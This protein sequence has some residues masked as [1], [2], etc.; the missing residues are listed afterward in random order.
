MPI[1]SEAAIDSRMTERAFVA[2]ER[3]YTW[4]IFMSAREVKLG[5]GCR[6]DFVAV[7]LDS[8][9]VFAFEVKASRSDWRNERLNPRKNLL[10]HASVDYWWIVAARSGIVEMDEIDKRDGLYVLA[11]DCLRVLAYPTRRLPEY[12]RYRDLVAAVLRRIGI[13]QEK[14][15]QLAG[16]VAREG[17]TRT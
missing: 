2:L 7:E 8:G 6:I 14:R 3:R 13:V 16:Q 5:D 11:E 17:G 9:N 10:A 12:A 1:R 15:L 4:P